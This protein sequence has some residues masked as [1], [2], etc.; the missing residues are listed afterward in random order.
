MRIFRRRKAKI[1]WISRDQWRAIDKLSLI[2]PFN[3]P[4]MKNDNVN[5]SSHI[6]AHPSQWQDYINGKQFLDYTMARFSNK[7]EDGNSVHS[8]D[9]EYRQEV[10]EAEK[11]ARQHTINE[12]LE[13]MEGSESELEEDN[14][15]KK[16]ENEKQTAPSQFSKSKSSPVPHIKGLNRQDTNV[17]NA[18]YKLAKQISKVQEE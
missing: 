17:I 11:K 15:E 18:K 1:P 12:R 4:N 9:E 7:D 5:L 3:Q 6:E 13:G 14:F 16:S 8:S 10:A 2:P